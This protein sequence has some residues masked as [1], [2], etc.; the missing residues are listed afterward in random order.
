MFLC[1]TGRPDGA[2]CR[3]PCLV[4]VWAADGKV[5]LLIASSQARTTTSS[6][7][8]ADRL[9]QSSIPL[10]V[11][12]KTLERRIGVVFRPDFCPQRGRGSDLRVCLW[13][14]GA[15]VG[16]RGGWWIVWRIGHPGGG[17]CGAFWVGRSLWS[18]AYHLTGTRLSLCYSALGILR[19]N[20][21]APTVPSIGRYKRSG[22]GGDCVEV[23][24]S[25]TELMN[26]HLRS[27]MWGTVSSHTQ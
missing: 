12:R 19:P 9:L 14:A 11:L 27:E 23:E 8:D 5:A 24:C 1:G 16:K 25:A 21:E 6:V 2:I 15:N 7:F 3:G 26:P 13:G 18:L 17:A 10:F 20:A 4:L 22:D